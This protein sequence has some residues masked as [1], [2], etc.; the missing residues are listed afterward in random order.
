MKTKLLAA[1]LSLA[2]LFG[3]QTLAAETCGDS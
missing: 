3:A 1:A 2:G